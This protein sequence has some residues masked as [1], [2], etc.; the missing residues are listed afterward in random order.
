MTSDVGEIC[1]LLNLLQG[2]QSRSCQL[3]LLLLHSINK[4]K[5]ANS[6]TKLLSLLSNINNWPYQ[7]GSFAFGGVSFVSVCVCVCA[8]IKSPFMIMI[9]ITQLS[10]CRPHLFSSSFAYLTPDS[11]VNLVYQVNSSRMVIITIVVCQC[12]PS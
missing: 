2:T 12:L 11:V 8:T 10:H 9:I 1:L 5:R 4:T 7:A 6:G 3:L